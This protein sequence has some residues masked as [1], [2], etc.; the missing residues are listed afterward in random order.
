MIV[1]AHLQSLLHILNAV[2]LKKIIKNLIWV[3][4][5]TECIMGVFLEEPSFKPMVIAAKKSLIVRSTE[6]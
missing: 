5:R 6:F 2:H 1:L 3:K 4:K